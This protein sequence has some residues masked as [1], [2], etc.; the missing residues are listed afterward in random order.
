MKAVV[1][2]VVDKYGIT[3]IKYGLIVF[4][5]TPVSSK[6]FGESFPTPEAMK[7]FI[8]VIRRS[9]GQ[10]N[11]AMALEEGRRLFDLAPKRPNARRVLVVIMDNKSI[12]KLEELERAYKPLQDK[13]IRVIAVSV[14]QDVDTKEMEQIS[15]DKDRVIQVNKDEKPESLVDKIIS[16]AT[17]KGESTLGFVAGFWRARTS[18][19]FVPL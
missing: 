13:N 19:F 15:G 18:A 6:N 9:N 16:K 7:N 14:G 10:P 3:K 4:G 12:N 8:N 11:L 5:T 17:V 1:K 2:A